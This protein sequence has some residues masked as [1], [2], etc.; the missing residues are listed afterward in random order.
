MSLIKFKRICSVCGKE[1]VGRQRKYCSKACYKKR[2]KE[3]VLERNRE[4][5]HTDPEYRKRKIK[6]NSIHHYNLYHND[7]EY[8]ANILEKMRERY[9]NDIE[10]KEGS[11]ERKRKRYRRI[12]GIPEDSKLFKESSIEIIIRK[13]LQDVGIEFEQE[14]YINLE[15]LT[16][17]YVDF[18]IEPNICLYCDGVYWHGSKCSETQ[19]RDKRICLSLEDMGY[20]VTRLS[21]MEI[22]DG[23]RP[24][25]LLEMING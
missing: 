20:Y 23:V 8:R 4:R 19:E 11:K 24:V 16:C 13:W 1:V 6:Q 7:A 2:V 9:Q 10:Y 25:E 12:R 18:F 22:L 17:T 14:F 15:N 3:M 5:Y 21:E